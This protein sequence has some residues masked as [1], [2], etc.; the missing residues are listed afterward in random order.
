MSTYTR[1]YWT[2]VI[3]LVAAAGLLHFLF[4]DR[5]AKNG[6]TGDPKFEMPT[7][8]MVGESIIIGMSLALLIG[9]I[10]V[11]IRRILSHKKQ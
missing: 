9:G 4:A 11:G 1:V 7:W 6:A 2:I 3:F 8:W 10:S 5:W